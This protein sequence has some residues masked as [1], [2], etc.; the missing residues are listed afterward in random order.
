MVAT[1]TGHVQRTFLHGARKL[2]CTML[3]VRRLRLLREVHHRGTLHAAARALDYSP[4]A[5]SQQLA[6]LEREAGT[7]LLEKAGRGVRLTDAALVLVDHADALLERLEA[8]EADLEAAAGRVAGTVRVAAFQT[9]ALHLVAPA[10]RALATSHPGIRVE[11]LDEE[12]EEATVTLQ[13]GAVDIAI[14]DEYEG[15]PRPRPAG[16]RRRVLL[17]E[18]VPLVLP[19]GHPYGERP[20][21]R[22]LRDAAWC[23]AKAGT[24]HREMTVRACRQ[25]GGFDPDVRHAS[26]DLVVL[27]ALVRTGAVCLLP[28]LVGPAEGV[29]FTTAA[30]GAVHRDVFALT[31]TAERP[32]VRAV[33]DALSAAAPPPGRGRA[34]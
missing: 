34:R 16:M 19:E 27:L 24:G 13:L 9:A 7:P 10:I 5:V 20:S 22:A 29:V 33:L 12:L 32:A 31:R 18:E 1:V 6:V 26:N 28:E 25:L 30:E 17:H 2:R 14:G 4:S 3:D 23:T 8:A 21:L 11:V 15:L